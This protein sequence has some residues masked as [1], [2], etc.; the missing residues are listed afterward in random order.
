MRDLL[1]FDPLMQS[2]F[3]DVE[4]NISGILGFEMIVIERTFQVLCF[5]LAIL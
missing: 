1:E 5:K 2:Q 3:L 4:Q